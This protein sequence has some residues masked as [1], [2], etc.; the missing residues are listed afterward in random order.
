MQDLLKLELCVHTLENTD[1]KIID[2]KG[3]YY[4]ARH[5]K[6]VRACVCVREKGHVISVHKLFSMDT[7]L[8][9]PSH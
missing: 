5:K 4:F 9:F 2:E 1:E 7:I 6:C 8:D 3:D